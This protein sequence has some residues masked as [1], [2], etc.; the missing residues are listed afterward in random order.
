MALLR[1]TI[2]P[3]REAADL[4]AYLGDAYDHERLVHYEAQLETELADIGD[5]QALYRRSVGYLYNLTAFA[6]TGTKDP[7]REWID[8]ALPAGGRLVDVGCGIGADGL[9]LMR[10]GG[11]QVT[12]ADFDNPSV[13]YLRTRLAALGEAGAAARIVDLDRESL[14]DGHDLAYAFDVLEHVEEPFALLASMEAAADLVLVNLLE[15]EPGETALHHELPVRD[16][17][18]HATARGL[19]RYR[20]FHGGRSHLVLYRG[21]APAQSLGLAARLRSRAVRLRGARATG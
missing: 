11:H 2:D 4:R 20:R 3:D 8:A 21:G 17:L 1:S 13:A 6:M 16:L 12:F 7:Y 5:E 19:V 18:D 15:P 10:G 9:A 14:P